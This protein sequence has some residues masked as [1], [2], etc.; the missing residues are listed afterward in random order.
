[1]EMLEVI[2]KRRSI[3]QYTDKPVPDVVVTELLRAAM[4]APSA[5]NEQ[6]WHFIVITDRGLLDEIPTFHPYSAMLKHAS[7]AVLVCGDMALE[8]HKGYWVQDCAAATENLLIAAAAKGLGAVWTGVYPE[9]ERV[10]GMRRL[11][12]LP[13]HVMPLSLVPIGYPAEFPPPAD[14]FNPDRVHKNRW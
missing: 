1:M 4:A 5:G 2:L 10:A 9:E 7:V 6:P 12:N 13:E 14:R 3:R 8:R 11:L